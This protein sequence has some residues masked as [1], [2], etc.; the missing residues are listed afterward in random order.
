MPTAGERDGRVPKLAADA[1]WLID[2]RPG[3]PMPPRRRK[4]RG[5]TT[6][7]RMFG[8]AAGSVKG[9]RGLRPH[10]SPRYA[11]SAVA[12]FWNDTVAIS[13]RYETMVT[14]ALPAGR[15]RTRMAPARAVPHGRG[16]RGSRSEPRGGNGLRRLRGVS[17][18]GAS[19]SPANDSWRLEVTARV[20]KPLQLSARPM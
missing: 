7:M 20:V 5:I 13:R 4:R 12:E 15:C 14:S 3:N 11:T 9:I 16:R 2:R 10:G 6:L 18:A 17:R 19:R 8:N 1:E